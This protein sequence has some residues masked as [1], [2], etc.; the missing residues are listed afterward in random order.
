MDYFVGPE[1]RHSPPWDPELCQKLLDKGH[2]WPKFKVRRGVWNKWSEDQCATTGSE[3]KD[4]TVKKLESGLVRVASC[5]KGLEV[6]Q[7]DRILEHLHS[8]G[9]I[10]TQMS[11]RNYLYKFPSPCH[12]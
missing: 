7:K 3:Y 11:G 5:P 10:H 12:A 4:L 1:Q 2:F 8:K 6:P 9:L